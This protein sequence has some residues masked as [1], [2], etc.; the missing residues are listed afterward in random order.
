[1]EPAHVQS[2]KVHPYFYCLDN[3]KLSEKHTFE[4][5]IPGKERAGICGGSLET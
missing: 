5:V 1:M 2:Q 3:I 4:Y